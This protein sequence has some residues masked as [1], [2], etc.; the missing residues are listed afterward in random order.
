MAKRVA[1]AIAIAAS[2]ERVW[3]LLTDFDAYEEWNPFVRRASGE[4]ALGETLQVAIAPPDRRA[5]TF[6]PVVTELRLNR[7]LRWKG[8]LLL[9]GLFNGDHQFRLRPT[10]KG[11]AFEHEERFTG[12]LPT[13]MNDAA[14]KRIERGFTLMNEALRRRAEEQECEGSK[15]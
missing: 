5:M 1:T 2:P 14:F 4:L 9:P 11:T 6:K 15:A 8:Q 7:L 13:L 3:Q 12:I 10:S